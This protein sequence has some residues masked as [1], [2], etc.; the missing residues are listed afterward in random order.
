MDLPMLG[1]VDPHDDTVFN[2]SQLRL[3][4]PELRA[5]AAVSPEAEAAAAHAILDLAALVERKPH[6]YLVFIGD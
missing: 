1:C 3:L 6:L 4:V 5:V 2:R